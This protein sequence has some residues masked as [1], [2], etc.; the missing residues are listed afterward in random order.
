MSTRISLKLYHKQKSDITSDSIELELYQ[1]AKDSKEFDAMPAELI[2]WFSSPISNQYD[3]VSDVNK[4]LQVLADISTEDVLILQ[5]Q[6]R[7]SDL[8]A[9]MEPNQSLKHTGAGIFGY[10]HREGLSANDNPL[11]YITLR[12]APWLD[13]NEMNNEQKDQKFIILG[14]VWSGM[15]FIRDLSLSL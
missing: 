12:P 2:E 6:W 11:F 3:S 14:R 5:P 9:S 7:L 8:N 13:Y 10:V 4:S 1:N 15:K